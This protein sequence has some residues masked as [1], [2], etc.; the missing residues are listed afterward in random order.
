M[1]LEFQIRKVQEEIREKKNKIYMKRTFQENCK[2]FATIEN[3]Y[4]WKLEEYK[5][6]SGIKDEIRYV[7]VLILNVKIL[8]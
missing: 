3:E 1:I 8:D 6:K 5:G 7:N 4:Q 2:S